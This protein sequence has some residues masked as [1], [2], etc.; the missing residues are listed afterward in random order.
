MKITMKVLSFSALLCLA[1]VSGAYAQVDTSYIY[2][3]AAPFGSLDIRIAKSATDYYYLQENKTF[4][5]RQNAGVNTDSYLDMTSWDSS[6]YM[7]GSLMEKTTAGDKF[8][9]NYRL[10]LPQGYNA[11]Y[12]SGYPIIVVL[13]GLRERANCYDNECYHATRSYSPVVNDPPAPTDGNLELLNND[14]QLSNGGNVHLIARNKA[15][16]KLP[17]DA[18]LDPRAFPGFI[19]FP[20]NLNGWDPSSAQ[21]VIRITRLISKKYNIDENRIYIHGLSNGGHGVFETIK[22][23]PWLFATALTMSAINDGFINGQNVAN[24]VAHIPMWMFQGGQDTNPN[25]QKTKSIIKKFRDAGAEVRYTEYPNLGHGTW[26]TAYN[27]KDFFTFMLGKNKANIHAFAGSTT[28]CGPQLTLELAPGFKA[29]QWQLNN[30]TIPGAASNTYGAT[31]PGTYRARF[32]RVANPTEAQW[33]RWSDPIEVKSGQSIA[34]AEIIQQGTVVLRDLNNGNDAKLEA[35]GEF[36][37]YYWYKDGTLVDFPGDQDDTIKTATITST[38]GKGV[39]TLITS[40]FDNCKSPVSAGKYLF[41]SNAAPINITAPGPLSAT[42]NAASEVT[43]SWTDASTN[44]GGFEIWRRRKID[45]TT[46]SLWEMATLTGAN[47]ATYKDT[48]LLPKATYQ[49]VIRAVS[50]TGRSNYTPSTGNVEVT[51]T[52]DTQPPTAPENL[53]ASPMGVSKMKLKWKP[54]TD[55]TGILKY[56]I[57]FGEDSVMTTNADTVLVLT[58]LDINQV[59]SFTV[60][61]I[62]FAGNYGPRS[63]P[64]EGS[65]YVAGLYYEHS[66]GVTESLDTID[67]STPEFTGVVQQ[68]TLAPKTQDDF[69]NFRF[70]GFLYINTAGSYQLRIGSDDGS[71]LKLDNAL[72][73]DNDGVHE[74]KTVESAAQNLAAGAHRIVVEFFEYIESDSL[75]VQFKG[76][77]SNNEW[78]TIPKTSLKSAENVITA[79]ESPGSLEDTFVVNIFPNPST[80]DNINVKLQSVQ[81]TPV[82]IQM[83]DMVGRTFASQ[84]VDLLQA[85]EG[86]KLTPV[87]HLRPGVYIISVKQGE[88]TARQRVVIRE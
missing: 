57:A 45:A 67:W 40:N 48:G 20:Q 83:I 66:T 87:E 42:P 9:M 6:P 51:T 29:Y 75:S 76:P 62:D 78:V 4:S 49:Y 28:I 65:T 18:T 12:A 85:A 13:H 86:V 3:N 60:R 38:M 53:T 5:F 16:S 11:T 71:S 58:D 56:L 50:N 19:L 68:F 32:S 2:N 23:A 84:I 69:F 39:Y 33:N 55:N 61:A 25:P 22:R 63:A 44:E 36:G 88:T 34:Q 82:Q 72:I 37:H 30:Q 43:L 24:T 52:A 70:D 77:D 31:T 26:G 15:G 47:I 35:K 7:Q 54:A 79:I 74:F 27:E 64:R 80:Q 21:D 81:N 17:D 10:L 1:V 14:H 8:A 59:Y 46:F 41:F 73:A